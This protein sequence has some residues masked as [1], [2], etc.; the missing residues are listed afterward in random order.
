[1]V[2]K[3]SEF[4]NTPIKSWF[5]DNNIETYSTNKE[6]ESGVAERFIKTLKNKHYKNITAVSKSIYIDELDYIVNE[7]NNTYHKTIN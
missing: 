1:M 4:Y 2:D 6:G 3:G 5:K 7:Y